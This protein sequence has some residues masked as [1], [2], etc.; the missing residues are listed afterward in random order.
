[1]FYYWLHWGIKNHFVVV[2][3][4]S[5]EIWP[6]FCFICSVV[7]QALRMRC[8]VLDWTQQLR[9]A[10][11]QRWTSLIQQHT[12]KGQLSCPG[13]WLYCNIRT[14]RHTHTLPHA[15]THSLSL[16]CLNRVLS[17]LCRAVGA[18]QQSGTSLLSYP[19]S[20]LANSK[21]RCVCSL[22][23]EPP[24]ISFLFLCCQVFF[25]I[26]IPFLYFLYHS[27][28]SCC[29]FISALMVHPVLLSMFF[30]LM[31]P[32]STIPSPSSSS[33][34]YWFTFQSFMLLY[35]FRLFY[36]NSFMLH[37]TKAHLFFC[38]VKWTF[39]QFLLR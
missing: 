36:S 9:P 25:Y 14:Y 33:F 31:Y 3:F 23:C 16:L 21:K 22:L 8:V 26:Y 38:L 10:E 30:H 19:Q 6:I 15:P 32:I 20:G 27:C 39:P 2:D 11:R 17:W 29:F 24:S 37:R 5:W 7:L 35:I 1:M 28:S 34:S 13:V 4:F 12:W 18:R